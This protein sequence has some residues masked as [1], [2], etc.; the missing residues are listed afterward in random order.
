[1]GRL[2]LARQKGDEKL[3]CEEQAVAT[4]TIRRVKHQ[5]KNPERKLLSS[6]TQAG[7]V[8]PIL[9]GPAHRA[10]VHKATA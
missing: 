9:R 6:I 2:A 7:G 5:S 4:S 3:I 10:H 1:M 8:T